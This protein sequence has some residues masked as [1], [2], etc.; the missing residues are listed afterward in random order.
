[1]GY[2]FALSQVGMEMAA[3]IG[4]G[5]WADV[6]WHTLPWL[7][8]VGAV[9]G[10]VGGMTHLVLLANRQARRKPPSQPRREQP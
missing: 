7:T 6:S 1:M 5:V 9:V 8:I 3:P 10:L 4:L 2:Y